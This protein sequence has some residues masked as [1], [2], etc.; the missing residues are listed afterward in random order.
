M[1]G[2]RIVVPDSAHLEAHLPDLRVPLEAALEWARR[3]LEGSP[4]RAG[5]ERLEFRAPRAVGVTGLAVIRPWTRGDFWAR[6]RGRRI[7]SHLIVGRKRLTRWLCVWGSWKDPATFELQ[8]L[9]PGRS[10]PREI[11]DPSIRAEELPEA[12]RFWGR[13]AIIVAEGEWEAQG[14]QNGGSKRS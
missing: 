9:Y 13:H 8:T 14:M 2:L 5:E 10:A 3:R 1:S 4:R 6:R 7:P 12:V 11:H